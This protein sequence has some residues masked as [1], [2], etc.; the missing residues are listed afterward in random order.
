MAIYTALLTDNKTVLRNVAF[1]GAAVD[2]VLP[3]YHLRS[4]YKPG[5]LVRSLNSATCRPMVQVRSLIGV[6][7]PGT[8]ATT[9]E[10][11]NSVNGS[12]TKVPADTTM[13]SLSDKLIKTTSVE[14]HDMKPK[15][16]SLMKQRAV[17]PVGAS[18][19]RNSALLFI[20]PEQFS[21]LVK[22]VIEQRLL[23]VPSLTITC[24]ATVAG[25]RA[26]DKKLVDLQYF[27]VANYACSVTP[28]SALNAI[29][30]YPSPKEIFSSFFR[31]SLNLVVSEKRIM[32]ARVACDL[33]SLTPGILEELWRKAESEQ[34][35]C[36]M[37]PKFY[38]ARLKVP[39]GDTSTM[40]YVVNGFYLAVRET[41]T[42]PNAM[43][44]C[45]EVEWNA[46]EMSWRDL[47]KKVIGCADPSQAYKGSIRRQIYDR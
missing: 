12:T 15:A 2:T 45:Y 40:V 4:T 27:Q 35:V 17:Q 39:T 41:F 44:H 13:S 22:D 29:H 9:G 37:A 47:R 38:C 20:K 23:E 6:L 42:N 30:S 16:S 14:E 7:C 1:V 19:Y 36:K 5:E 3:H 26:Q 32:N 34:M 31:E 25:R 28:A 11:K 21:P 18:K 43:T 46:S 8:Y 10:R 24:Q 33:F